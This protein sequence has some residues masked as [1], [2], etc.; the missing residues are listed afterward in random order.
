MKKE[1]GAPAKKSQKKISWLKKFL[2]N[3]RA[4]KRLI[5]LTV[6]LSVSLWLFWGIPLPTS[7]SSRQYPVSTKLFDR[8][9]KLIYEIYS[10][11]RRTPVKLEDLPEYVKSSTIAVEDKDFYKH[12]GFSITGIG[13]AAYNIVF[14]RKLQGGS[15][16]TQQLVKNTLLTPQRT[17]RRKIREFLLSMIVEG[18]Y[19]KDQILEMYLNQIPYGSTAYGIEAA[20]ELYLGKSAKDLSLAEATLLAGLP[21]A[22]TRYSP[23]GA[24]PELAKGRQET[25]LRRM[26]EDGY[27]SQSDADKAKE[28]EIKYAEIAAPK[29]PHFALWVKEQLVEKYGDVAVEQGGLR[30]TTTL[31][32]DLQEFTQ[33]AVAAEVEKL[34]QYDVG[35]GATIVTRP[36]TGEILAMVGSK[37]YFAQDEDGK[38][39]VTLAKRQPGSAIKPLNYALALKDKKITAATPLADVPTCFSVVGQPIYCPRNY[40]GAFHGLVQARFALGNSYNLPAVKVLALNGV[41]NF[42]EFAK[43]MGISTF[44]DPSNYGLSLT[45]GG[46]EVTPYDMAVAFGVF[47]NQGIKVPLISIVKV[48][49]WKGKILEEINVDEIEGDRVLTPDVTFIIS[50][51]LHDNNARAGAFGASSFLNVR[52]HPEVS[53]KTGTTNDRRD[54]WTIGFTAHALTATW[55]GNNDNSPMSAAVSGVSGASPIWN[56]VM[57]EVLDKAE[58][59]FYN[60]DDEGHAWPRQ[61]EEVAGATVCA[62]TGILPTDVEPNAGC[63]TRFEYF[64]DGTVATSIE[65]GRRDIFIDKTIGAPTGNDTPPELIETQNHPVIFDPLGALYCLDCAL[66]VQPTTIKYPL[67]R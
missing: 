29:A 6:L 31:D 55:V 19:A 43:S 9:G 65:G 22:P 54:N 45:L 62:T 53:V 48:E 58:E 8:K 34:A 61:P 3:R 38:V 27:L 11:K 13:R 35:N 59:G 33:N 15:T 7:L 41:E 2:K 4:V 23:F 40:D 67:N 1:S 64:L 10:D 18:I 39:N 50:H 26:V 63:P 30:V 5:F 24:H 49:D 28:E 12:Q 16:L 57:R 42:V 66:P 25:V 44:T 37:D 36:K 47:A 60:P 14:K 46:G 17:I 21:A 52:G 51:I 20:S 56:A 32:L